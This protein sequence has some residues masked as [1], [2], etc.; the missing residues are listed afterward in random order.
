MLVNDPGALAIDADRLRTHTGRVLE[1]SDGCLCFS[2]RIGLGEAL[3]ALTRLPRPPAHLVIETSGMAIP[4][5]LAAQLPLHGLRLERRRRRR[6]LDLERIESLWHDPWVGAVVR[7][8]FQGVDWLQISKADRLEPASAK[9]R[10][11]WLRNRLRQERREQQQQPLKSALPANPA[12]A[13]NQ[14]RQAGPLPA[15]SA[16]P[17]LSR[18]VAESGADGADQPGRLRRPHLAPARAPVK[19][20]IAKLQPARLG[21][22]PLGHVRLRLVQ[23]GESLQA[24]H[25]SGK[26]SINPSL[27]RFFHPAPQPSA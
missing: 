27:K 24:Q 16:E 21:D 18:V 7:Q 22:P 14:R 6:R 17:R 13:Q 3:L 11:R 20:R 1:L 15:L 26:T 25:P 2:M 12:Q 5:R 8:Q 23:G 19:P 10:Q 4:E 9:A